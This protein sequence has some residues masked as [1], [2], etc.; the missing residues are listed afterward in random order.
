MFKS[1]LRSSLKRVKYEFE[2]RTALPENNPII[3]YSMR[4]VGSTTLTS[5]LRGAGHRVYKQHCVD[6]SLNAELSLALERTGLTPQH[7][8]TD[9][10][11]FRG[12]LEKWRARANRA[13]KDSRL[14][15]FSFVRDPL[16]V[17]LSDYFMQ[18]NEFMPKVMV[19]KG[20]DSVEKLGLYFET[21][22]HA[23]L[24]CNARDPVTGFLANL[25]ALP[26]I[27]FDREMKSVTGV[28]VLDMPFRIDRGYSIYHGHDSDI[29]LIRTDKLSEVALESIAELIGKQLSRISEKNVGS[30][31]AQGELYRALVSTIRLPK[32]L[33]DEFYSQP[34]LTHF[35]S[36][37]EIE[38]MKAKWYRPK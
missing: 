34:W 15:I 12:R 37:P 29:V 33:V 28:D 13:H 38:N 23:A 17:A 4:K 5:A 21:V 30:K 14:K 16:A 22:L 26:N 19:S 3:V 35:F 25:S 10:L 8:L 7:W 32:T 36:E 1:I 31:T 20:L 11:R 6:Y 24:E 18:L 2:S 9:G 27:W